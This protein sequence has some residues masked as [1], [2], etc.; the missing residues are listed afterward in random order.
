M[1]TSQFVTSSRAR[2]NASETGNFLESHQS[3]ALDV[4]YSTANP[5]DGSN[6]VK[7]S[8]D[9]SDSR[10]HNMF[11]RSRSRGRAEEKRPGTAGRSSRSKSRGR[12]DGSESK[13]FLGRSRSARTSNSKTQDAAEDLTHLPLPHLGRLDTFHGHNNDSMIGVAV[14][15]PSQLR[16]TYAEPLGQSSLPTIHADTLSPDD[17]PLEDSMN[18]TKG[19]KWKKIGGL[20][21]ARNAFANDQVQ[22][23]FH[24]LEEHYVAGAANQLQSSVKYR[25]NDPT[26]T[27]QDARFLFDRILGS[28]GQLGP[29]LLPKTQG[30]KGRKADLLGSSVY[31]S[32]QLPSKQFSSS[33]MPLLDVEIPDV[34][35]ERY[36]VMFG[37]LLDKQEPPTLLSRRDKARNKMLTISDEGEE[38]SDDARGQEQRMERSKTPSNNRG[39]SNLLPETQS[40]HHRRATSPTTLKSPSFSLFPQ[41]SQA[42]EK[43]VGHVSSGQRSPLQRSFTAPARM[44][45]MRETFG[46][47]TS[48]STNAGDYGTKNKRAA[49][50]SQIT[51]AFNPGIRSIKEAVTSLASNSSSVYEDLPQE[52]GYLTR[53]HGQ[54]D[55]SWIMTDQALRVAPLKPRNG[56]VSTQGEHVTSQKVE[57]EMEEARR[58]NIHEDTLS[59]L[60]RPRS[61]ASRSKDA[62]YSLKPSKARIDQI[63]CGAIPQ[64]APASTAIVQ[65]GQGLQEKLYPNDDP[66][67]SVKTSDVLSPRTDLA[68]GMR[69]LVTTVGADGSTPIGKPT[70]VANPHEQGAAS[71]MNQVRTRNEF[72]PRPP[73]KPVASLQQPL[74]SSSDALERLEKQHS[75]AINGKDLRSQTEFR[76]GYPSQSVHD[77]K[78]WPF[79]STDRHAQ[80]HPPP[81]NT[82]HRVDSR[83]NTSPRDRPLF[84]G[85]NRSFTSDTLPQSTSAV[86][87]Q[88]RFHRTNSDTRPRQS[89][90]NK[91]DENIIDYY[92][93][94]AK[95]DSSSRLSKS[96]KKLQK[97][98]NT[99]RKRSSLTNKPSPY[100]KWE[101][102]SF[103]TTD[104]PPR[105]PIPISKYS[106]NAAAIQKACYS[107]VVTSPPTKHQYSQSHSSIFTSQ[108]FEDVPL[109]PSSAP[110]VRRP[111]N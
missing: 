53:E 80:H 111:N 69:E 21:K 95:P 6:E 35:M 76:T 108:A 8:R 7:G 37:S 79:H 3:S 10:T 89:P 44:S 78:G 97:R 15:S 107:P 49:S 59:A 24:Q 31:P 5:E 57:T 60:E 81:A 66:A 99:S 54:R 106:T 109:S 45:P 23:P 13:C 55:L 28:N 68:D 33:G 73:Q 65:E 18:K 30:A 48:E 17:Y 62:S 52:F 29:H 14:G 1:A 93:D 46:S 110:P 105:S 47:D 100:P 58:A 102:H 104:R 96:P 85:S 36:S 19:A 101:P 11:S 103:E 4:D 20:F 71:T 94:Y 64:Q 61:V 70:P 74:Q 9:P 39:V 38:P 2:S 83:Q 51:S 40:A 50:P 43:I 91:D 92:L 72:G 25:S 42:P 82:S 84:N 87:S 90:S 63:M 27:D 16:P 77:G 67:T 56:S 12:R 32:T 41:L 22:S 98:S 34:Q 88:S 86:R 26:P 75:N